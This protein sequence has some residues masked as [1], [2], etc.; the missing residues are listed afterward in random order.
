[1]GVVH[2]SHVAGSLLHSH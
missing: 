1:M 2:I